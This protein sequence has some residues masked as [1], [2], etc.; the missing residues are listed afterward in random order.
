MTE[1]L[2]QLIKRI[3]TREETFVLRGAVNKDGELLILYVRNISPTDRRYYIDRYTPD[4]EFAERTA[5]DDTVSRAHDKMDAQIRTRGFT[6]ENPM[7][8][9]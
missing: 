1:K 3:E 5:E 7:L 8:K 9:D 4:G 2:I 6:E